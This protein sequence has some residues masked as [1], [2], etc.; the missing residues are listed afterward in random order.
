MCLSHVMNIYFLQQRR[1]CVRACMRRR[2]L[3]SLKVVFDIFCRLQICI[4]VPIGFCA[5]AKTDLQQQQQNSSD[6]NFLLPL[7]WWILIDSSQISFISFACVWD[8]HIWLHQIYL[9]I[10]MIFKRFAFKLLNE[11]I[12]IGTTMLAAAQSRKSRQQIPYGWI[13]F[14]LDSSKLC[15]KHAQPTKSINLKAKE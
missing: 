12:R 3:A 6:F 2:A 8:F 15:E 7:Q 9:L 4:V 10:P 11:P 14:F 13:T 1:W 5:N